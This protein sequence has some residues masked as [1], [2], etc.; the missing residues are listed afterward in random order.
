MGV[1]QSSSGSVNGPQK[2]Y[3]PDDWLS[4][5]ESIRNVEAD[6]TIV[7]LVVGSHTTTNEFDQIRRN[8]NP[9]YD[10]V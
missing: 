3:V 6:G 9:L 4:K 7:V 5:S 10:N 2:K 1:G 8:T